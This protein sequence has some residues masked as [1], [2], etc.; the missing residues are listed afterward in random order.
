MNISCSLISTQK[1]P[2]TNAPTL[3]VFLGLILVYTN[4]YNITYAILLNKTYVILGARGGE[5]G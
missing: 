4:L 5:L 1:Y 2:C 3:G